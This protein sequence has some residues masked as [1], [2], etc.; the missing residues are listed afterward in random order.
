M[1]LWARTVVILAL[2][3]IPLV[4]GFTVYRFV[5]E[6][7]ALAVRQAE[8]AALRIQRRPRLACGGELG[9]RGGR[10]ARRIPRTY[11]YD[12]ALR[13]IGAQTPPMSEPLKRAIGALGEGDEIAHA[14]SPWRGDHDMIGASAVLI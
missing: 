1:R 4:T 8:R 7:R 9:R 3:M 14:S 10:R 2:V 5:S 12:A 13:P 6:R 11:P